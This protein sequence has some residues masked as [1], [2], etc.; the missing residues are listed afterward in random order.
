ML[1]LLLI[2]LI[3][4]WK[5]LIFDFFSI[6]FYCGIDLIVEIVINFDEFWWGWI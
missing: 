5:E 6:C 4:G 1:N 2:D 3:F